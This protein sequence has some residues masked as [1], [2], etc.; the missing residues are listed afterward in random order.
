MAD[1]L[2]INKVFTFK[3][4]YTR[5]VFESACYHVKGIANSANTWVG[6][7]TWE[8]RVFIFCNHGIDELLVLSIEELLFIIL[9]KYIKIHCQ[10]ILYVI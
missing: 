8:D 6:V 10:I 3:N 5:K 4:R 2:P 7:E 1:L 9:I